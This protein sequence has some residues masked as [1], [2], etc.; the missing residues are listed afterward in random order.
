MTK[1]KPIEHHTKYK[2]IHGVAE[3]TW[4]TVSEH[5]TLHNRLRKSGKCNIPVDELRKISKSAHSRTKKSIETRKRY[6]ES[7]RG[8]ESKKKY[9]RSSKKKKAYERY[10]NKIIQRIHFVETYGKNTQLYEEITYNENTGNV[11]YYA[12]FRGVHKYKIPVI[13]I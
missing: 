2:E 3:T 8:K 9:D 13:D 7:E 10:R 1:E 12:A 5:K 6:R 4:I 11:V